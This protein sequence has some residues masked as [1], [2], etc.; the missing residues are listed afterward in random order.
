M[1]SN[2]VYLINLRFIGIRISLYQYLAYTNIFENIAQCL[3]HGFTCAKN[4]DTT[5]F[6]TIHSFPGEFCILSSFNVYI[7]NF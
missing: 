3:F 7:L 4:W 1:S 2:T 5:N 6:V